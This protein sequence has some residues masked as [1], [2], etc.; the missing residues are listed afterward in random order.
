MIL[1]SGATGTN[2]TEILKRLATGDVQV[3]AMVRS[4]DRASTIVAEHRGCGG[5]L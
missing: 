5:E 1:V 2:G 4:L 3:R